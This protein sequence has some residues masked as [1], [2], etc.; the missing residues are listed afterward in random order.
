M[1]RRNGSPRRHFLAV[2]RAPHATPVREN[3][4][5]AADHRLA[6][7]VQQARETSYQ[8]G[9]SDQSTGRT[10]EYRGRGSVCNVGSLD[11][12]DTP[13]EALFPRTR[14]SRGWVF[15]KSVQTQFANRM[16]HGGVAEANSLGQR[17]TSSWRFGP[18]GMSRTSCR[19]SSR[20]RAAGQASDVGREPALWR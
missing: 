8:A 12:N 6:G 14:T 13:I 5:A 16:R 7:S 4:C 18:G 2:P 10:S 15:K 17:P 1:V 19:Y 3:Q 9:I 20:V 11:A